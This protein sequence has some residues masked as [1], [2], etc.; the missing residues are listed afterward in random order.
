MSA[1][2]LCPL[3]EPP[4]SAAHDALSGLGDAL[5]EAVSKAREANAIRPEEVLPP[6]PSAFTP[7]GQEAWAAVFKAGYDRAHPPPAPETKGKKEA[8]KK[9]VKGKKGA[10]EEPPPPAT[11]LQVALYR[12]D[13][14][15]SLSGWL[16]E[17]AGRF[18]ESALVMDDM[19]ARNYRDGKSLSVSAKAALRPSDISGACVLLCVDLDVA[20]FLTMSSDGEDW[21]LPDHA[22]AHPHSPFPSAVETIRQVLS[23]GPTSLIISSRLRQ[24]Y[25]MNSNNGNGRTF[26]SNASLGGM[27]LASAA[28]SVDATVPPV[29]LSCLIGTRKHGQT[30]TSRA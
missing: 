10:V 11:P 20:N 19:A 30:L 8:P 5:L 29:S 17:A 24:P 9:E 25:G 2:S 12:H 1:S 21:L 22:K 7:H 15:T 26:S 13:L 18:F 16:S 28:G 3:Q 23:H 6:L 27:S 14:Y 4:L